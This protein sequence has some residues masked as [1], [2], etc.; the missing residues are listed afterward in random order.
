MLGREAG[1]TVTTTAERRNGTGRKVLITGGAGGM[2]LACAARMG[3]SGD[4][5]LL[6]DVDAD[7][8]RRAERELARAGIEARSFACDLADARCGDAI[9]D[10]LR[11]GT[12]LGAL[13]HTAGLS[14]VMA[15]W[16]TIVAVDLVGTAR[17]LDAALAFVGPGSAAVCVA[18]MA[19][20]LVPEDPA[21][22]ALMADPLRPDL[23][24]A[25][26]ALPGAPVGT[27]A[28]AYAHAK[29]AVRSLVARSAPAWGARGARIVSLSPGMI[30]TPMGKLEFERQPAMKMLLERTPL[31]RMGEPGD[32]AGVV[33]FLC[34]P[35]AAF[36]TGCDLLVD[37]GV[38]AALGV[39]G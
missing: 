6:T 39:A 32:I 15:D 36:V 29:R 2:G 14:P 12:P 9:A 30:E 21:V 16:R 33:A 7:A 1:R 13:V 22:A 26:A 23:L 28:G 19:G 38:C 27:S 4:A 17:V 10:A 35:D 8:L 34:S 3:A 5:I 25:L 37:G 18:S 24:D 31:R 11:D 20:H